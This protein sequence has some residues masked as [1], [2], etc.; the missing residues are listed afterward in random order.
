MSDI[1]SMGAYLAADLSAVFSYDFT[2]TCTVGKRP[3]TVIVGNN[4]VTEE[5]AYGGPTPVDTQEIHFRTSDL[6]T[7]ENGIIITLVDQGETKKKLVVSSLVSAD[8]N[9]LIV[10][11]RAA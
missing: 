3:Y 11:V 4:S 6:A 1:I 10:N 7:I 8:G 5:D 2:T 9:E